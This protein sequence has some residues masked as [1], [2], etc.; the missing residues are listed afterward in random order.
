MPSACRLHFSSRDLHEFRARAADEAALVVESSRSRP[1]RSAARSRR[2]RCR[3][4]PGRTRRRPRGSPRRGRAAPSRPASGSP[5]PPL[6]A[7]PARAS[8]ARRRAPFAIA[9]QEGAGIEVMVSVSGRSPPTLPTSRKAT[10]PYRRTAG[11]GCPPPGTRSAARTDP[12]LSQIR[13][14]LGLAHA[15]AGGTR[16]DEVVRPEALVRGD[17]VARS[18]IQEILQESLEFLGVRRGAVARH[19]HCARGT[20]SQ[21]GSRFVAAYGLAR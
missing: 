6:S 12:G 7:R 19:G 8:P 21:S 15:H 16:V 17:I 3:K 14:D 1:Q 10:T 2:R 20:A 13:E 4:T 9:L 11:C 5:P 18:A